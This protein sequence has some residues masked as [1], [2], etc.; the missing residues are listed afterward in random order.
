MRL[1][2]PKAN[3]RGDGAIKWVAII[4][5]L[6]LAAVAAVLF[7][8]Q[9]RS[10]ARMAELQAQ[11]AALQAANQKLEEQQAAAEEARKVAPQDNIE[12]VRLRGEVASLRPLQKQVQQL[13]TENQQL[14]TQI[15][16][17]Q[18]ANADTAALRSQNQQL[19]GAIQS[20]AQTDA[21]IGN[22]R[23]IE[24]AKAAWAAQYQKQPIDVPTE[25]DLFGPGKPLPQKPVC[26]AGGIYTLGAVQARPACNIPGHAY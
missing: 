22:L 20:K 2:N 3:A 13:Q 9:T 6:A 10:K 7:S 4:C 26:P 12:L 24:A 16:Q 19:Q 18:Q 21:C 17:L 25:F 23:N 11:Q 5:I 1:H 8:A 14:K 15:Q